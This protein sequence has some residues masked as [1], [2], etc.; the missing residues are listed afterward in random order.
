MFFICICHLMELCEE[1]PISVAVE[2]RLLKN[3]HFIMVLILLGKIEK[4]KKERTKKRRLSTIFM[5]KN[6]ADLF[7]YAV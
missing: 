4:W 7:V 6:S 5:I 1:T 2:S 3:F